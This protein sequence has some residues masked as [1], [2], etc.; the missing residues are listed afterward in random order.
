MS[1]AANGGDRDLWIIGGGGHAK[2]VIE[3]VRAEGRFRPVGILDDDARRW[4]DTVLGVPIRG[5]IASLAPGAAGSARG[6]L[7]IGDNRRRA[8]LDERIGERMTWPTI[9]HPSSVVSPS[10]TIAG[11]AVVF[12]GVIVQADARVGRH[13]I[14]NTGCSVDHDSV[15]DDFAHLA[16]GV[17]LA[18]GVHVEEGALLGIGSSV[19]PYRTVG[20]WSVVGAGGVVVRNIPSSVT[21]RGIPARVETTR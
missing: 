2:V 7:A 8:M 20:A 4:G 14:L 19:I 6:V 13:V 10:A 5:A 21:A 12:A 9:V 11:G 15:I 18:G 3:A 16:P 17:R 1:S